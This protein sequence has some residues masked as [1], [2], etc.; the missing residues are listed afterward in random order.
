MSSYENYTKTSASY[1]GSR[2]PVGVQHVLAELARRGPLDGLTILDAGCG[3]GQFTA[4]LLPHVLRVEAIDLNPGMLSAARSKFGDDARVGLREG[5]IAELPYADDSMDGAVI[6]QVLHHLPDDSDWSLHRRVFAELRRVIRPGGTFVLNTC[7]REQVHHGY[8]YFQLMPQ[9]T[10]DAMAVRYAPLS[11]VERLLHEV[12]FD[13]INRFVPVDEL[14]Q[15]VGY[16][17]PRAPLDSEWRDGDSTWA[18]L[19]PAELDAI[20]ERVRRLDE[21]GTLEAWKTRADE[22]RRRLGQVTLLSA[23]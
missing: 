7:A 13:E 15:P 6:N 4:E 9:R 5:S 21:E 3:T 8:W 14:I 19:E 18:L 2:R 11:V 12:G 1:D 16:H 10:R 20:L 17:D 22:G 23:R